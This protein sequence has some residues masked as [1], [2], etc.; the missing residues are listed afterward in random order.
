MRLSSESRRV[1]VKNSIF[2]LTCAARVLKSKSKA[3]KL[4]IFWEKFYI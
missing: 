4:F 3:Q 1:F 2:C